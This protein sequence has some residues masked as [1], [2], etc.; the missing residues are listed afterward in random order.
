VILGGIFLACLCWFFTFGLSW[1][2][3][4][5]KIGLSVIAVSTYALLCQ[6][7]KI[8]FRTSSVVWGIFSAAV[9]YGV[10]YAGNA[11]AP[12]FFSSAHTNVD[13]IY[14]LGEGTHKLPIFFLLFLITGPGE[15]IFWRGFLQGNLMKRFGPFTG[16]VLTTLVYGG[17]HLFSFN[18]MLVLAAF[19]AG[20]FWGVL[21]LLK[22]DLLLLIVSHSLWSSVIFAIAP[23]Q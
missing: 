11:L 15:E 5:V 7:P 23:I 8:A 9:L 20:A 12:H 13:K 19:V 14:V 16:F 6:K 3:F 17:V 22:R 2:N 1:G 4:W 18:L 10:F 21:F